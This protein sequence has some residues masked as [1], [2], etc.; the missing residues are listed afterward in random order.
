V[1]ASRAAAYAAWARSGKDLSFAPALE[2][3]LDL[4][5]PAPL[6]ILDVGCGEGRVG[7]ELEQRRYAVVGVDS[8]AAMVELA[9][10]SHEAVAA[11]ACSL[12]FPDAAFD[13]VVSVHAL[14][15]I[16]ALE[17]ALAEMARVLVPDGVLV[18]VIEHPLA[19]GRRVE[20]YSRPER[21]A[22]PLNHEGVDLGL[23]GIHRPLGTYVDALERSDLRLETLRETSIESS[24]P[25]SLALRARRSAE[26][27]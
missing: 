22:W 19:S 15:E 26:P 9:Q 24:D 25:L 8:D 11:D 4:L 10:E 6:R 13:A 3:V 7:R 14:M 18:A 2:A 1:A 23:G 27:S 17:D 12:P 5:P 20:R 21:Y 16:E